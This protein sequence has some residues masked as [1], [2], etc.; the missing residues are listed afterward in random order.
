VCD[1]GEVARD[2]I[3][4]TVVDTVGAGD[5]FESGLLDSLFRRGL[6]GH[7]ARDRLRAIDLDTLGA[8]LDD[9]G[10]VSAITVGR[11]GADPPTAAELAT[12]PPR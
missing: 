9:A 10:L 6:L 4:V 7:D 2:P 11:P 1:A 5:A 8:V 3:P 12:R